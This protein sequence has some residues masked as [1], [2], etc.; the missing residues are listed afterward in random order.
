MT[1]AFN[2]GTISAIGT[3]ESSVLRALVLAWSRQKSIDLRVFASRMRYTGSL[4]EAFPSDNP[5]LILQQHGGA[6]G[7]DSLKSLE[8][9]FES[10]LTA[11][12]RRKQGAVYTPIPIT[13]YLVTESFALLGR[14]PQSFCDPA[15]GAGAFLLAAAEELFKRGCDPLEVVCQTVAGVDCNASALQCSAIL[16]ELLLLQEKRITVDHPLNLRQLDTLIAGS[17]G[18]RALGP[19]QSGFDVLAT[20]PPYV[21]LQSLDEGYRGVLLEK[22]SHLVRGSFS[23]APL[24]LQ[25]MSEAHTDGGVAAVITQ[26]NLFTSLAGEPIRKHLQTRRRLRRVI[27]FGHQQVFPNASTYTCLVFTQDRPT[28]AFEYALLDSSPTLSNL[29]SAMFTDVSYATLNPKKWRFGQA[30]SL[31]NLRKVEALG[32]P[33]GTAFSIRV[34]FATLK[35]KVFLLGRDQNS[36]FSATDRMGQRHLIE[37]GLTRPAVRV[38]DLSRSCSPQD[39]QRRIIFPYRKVGRRF[40]ALEEMQLRDEFP[41]GYAYLVAQRDLLQTRS[42][43]ESSGLPW[44][45]WG[46]SQ[47]ME[48]T[49]PKLLT[50]T[51]DRGPHFH[52]DSSD[53]LFCNGY[54][55]FPSPKG[56]LGAPTLETL[57]V[58][59]NSKV[60]YY[61]SVLT[62]FQIAGG[63]QCYQK[64]FI[65]R[66]GVPVLSD[67]QAAEIRA[68]SPAD[69]E[70]MIAHLYG[71]PMS[72]IDDQL[73]LYQG[74]S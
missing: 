26:N 72:L 25:V 10:L 60:M 34:G 57:Q 65:E 5:E 15:C 74:T 38:A 52:W 18:I 36:P 40:F 45:A 24:F 56:S 73:S 59:L 61:Y 6:L 53:A 47:G 55:V 54:A 49:G 11:E 7:W 35:D 27:D 1:I 37:E 9:S 62:T 42:G 3:Y 70:Q 13:Q 66:F 8:K 69:R 39:V 50:K 32:I 21:K 20:N 29:Q 28:D 19:S 23:L 68:A 17:D 43:S 12:V 14:T 67:V 46:R 44:Y 41:L 31:S 33:L 71:I 51:F 58:L 4:L 63:Y 2:A 64:N 48:A 16:M 30:N 22:Y